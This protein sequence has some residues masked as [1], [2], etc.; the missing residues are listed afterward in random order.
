MIRSMFAMAALVFG[1]G[2][3]DSLGCG[4]CGKPPAGGTNAKATPACGK[5]CAAGAKGHDHGA[6][7]PD[8]KEAKPAEGHCGMC[9]KCCS[10]TPA[11]K[12]AEP[13]KEVKLTGTLVC[14]KCQLKQT[15]KC[16]NVLQVKEGDKT[17]NYFLD[18]KGNGELYHEGVC[19]GDKVEGVAVTGTVTEKDSK[20]F[21]KPTKVE[22]PKK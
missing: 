13:A 7:A 5:C 3:A 14:G 16:S 12:A 10:A 1:V 2:Q 11:D 18:D 21:V 4:G 8:G 20:K 17:V 9:A 19:G 15:P 6:K 22:L